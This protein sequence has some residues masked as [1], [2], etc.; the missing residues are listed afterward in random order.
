MCCFVLVLGFLGP[1]F[2]FLFAWLA[3]DRVTSAFPGTWLI[4]LAAILF[5]PWTGL[6][7]I[8]AWAPGGIGVTGVGWA[9][10]AL[11]LIFDIATY[12]GRAA[13]QRM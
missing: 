11:G 10:V 12:S 9:V 8:A 5:L 1:R 6:A 3:T 7:Y 2:A 4:P 13:Q